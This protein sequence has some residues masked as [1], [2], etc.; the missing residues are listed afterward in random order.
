MPK[1]TPQ[2]QSSVQ[3]PDINCDSKPHPDYL[4]PE[5]ELVESVYVRQQNPVRSAVLPT[6]DNSRWLTRGWAFQEDLMFWRTLTYLEH[7]LSWHCHS[8]DAWE[9]G[10]TPT[11]S[12]HIHF[13]MNRFLKRMQMVPRE[14]STVDAQKDD[15][16]LQEWYNTIESYSERELSRRSDRLPA[17]VGLARIWQKHVKDTYCAGLWKV[18]C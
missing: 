7:Q 9:S 8:H 17:T 10:Y 15:T 11:A 12:V 3:L 16:M 5:K 14:W 1:A 18:T 13:D 2:P 6:K 4:L